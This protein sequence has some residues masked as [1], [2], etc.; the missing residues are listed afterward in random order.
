MADDIRERRHRELRAALG[1]LRFE[2]HELA[3]A[4]ADRVDPD[5]LH[6]VLRGM[7]GLT[8]NNERVR[9]ARAA[10]A[11]SKTPEDRRRDAEAAIEDAR[12]P[13]DAGGVQPWDLPVLLEEAHEN[14]GALTL[15]E[16]APALRRRGRGAG[17]GPHAVL[18]ELSAKAGVPF[19]STFGKQRAKK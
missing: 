4:Y 19:E 18:R 11:A 3:A 6:L 16:V 12:T 10:T 5:L 14:F 2:L 1:L 13:I 15:A 17:R 7:L 9:L 8:D